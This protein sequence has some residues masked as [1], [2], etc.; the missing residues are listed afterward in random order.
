MKKS[1]WSVFQC[2]SPVYRTVCA[3]RRR[4]SY[5]MEAAGLPVGGGVRAQKKHRPV[6]GLCHCWDD[7][8]LMYETYYEKILSLF[9]FPYSDV[10]GSYCLRDRTRGGPLPYA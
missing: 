10:D 4:V 6:S 3:P 9:T 2:P 1:P 5:G 7:A 8:H